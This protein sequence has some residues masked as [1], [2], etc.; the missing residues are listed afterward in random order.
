[1]LKKK[2]KRL[3]RHISALIYG[4]IFCLHLLQPQV[5]PTPLHRHLKAEKHV[6]E[7]WAIQLLLEFTNRRL[8]AIASISS[9]LQDNG[10]FVFS[11]IYSITLLM[12]TK[13]EIF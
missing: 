2:R 4:P 1:M 11:N 6:F 8:T 5:L 3:D 9:P 12:S 13:A 10:P 7:A